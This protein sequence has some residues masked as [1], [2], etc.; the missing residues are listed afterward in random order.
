MLHGNW[1]CLALEAFWVSMKD[2]LSD[3]FIIYY[4]NSDLY[5]EEKDVTVYYFLLNIIFQILKIDI[6]KKLF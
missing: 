2:F 1:G 4:S 6:F 5:V 3:L